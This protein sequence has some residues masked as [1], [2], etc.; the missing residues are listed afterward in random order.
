MTT[1]DKVKDIIVDSLSCDEEQVTLEASLKDDLDADSLDAVE[2][3]MADEFDV[4]IP[5]EEANK[6]ATVKDI[7][8]YLEAN[9]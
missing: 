1:F 2:L 4:Q 7:V 3:I 8:D 5:D 6:M 9:A